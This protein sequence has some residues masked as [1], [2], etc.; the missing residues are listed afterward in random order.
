[1]KT[2]EYPLVEKI[3]SFEQGDLTEV[4][5]IALFQNLVDTGLAWKLQGSYGRMAKTLLDEE[6]I[7]A[8]NA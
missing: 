2:Q 5:I 7:S 1:M 4:E 3:I 6:L 8:P